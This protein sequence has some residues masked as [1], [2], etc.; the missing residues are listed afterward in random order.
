MKEHDFAKGM[1]MGIVVGGAMGVAM[2][3]KKR[4]SIQKAADKAM[5]TMGQV[6]EELSD[7]MGLH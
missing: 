2:A 3:P 5:K 4:S 6:M 1:T 7:E